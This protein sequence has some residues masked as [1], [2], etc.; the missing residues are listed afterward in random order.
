MLYYPGHGSLNVQFRPTDTSLIVIFSV[1]A[2]KDS[3]ASTAPSVTETYSTMN[4][5]DA[6]S[7]MKIGGISAAAARFA[8]ERNNQM[9][10]DTMFVDDMSFSSSMVGSPSGL[11]S[12]ISH[13]PNSEHPPTSTHA[14]A[15]AIPIR[16]A[17]EHSMLINPLLSAPVPQDPHYGEFNY[18]QRR[19]RKTSMDLEVRRVSFFRYISIPTPQTLTQAIVKEA[20]CRLLPTRTTSCFYHHS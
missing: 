5:F 17:R 12:G 13:S 3:V 4:F 10:T 20:T 1:A 6:P 8:S 15:C 18:V 7:T 11:S 16:A 19:V 9:D 2:H 14:T